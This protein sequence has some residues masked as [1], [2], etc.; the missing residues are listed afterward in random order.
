LV[1]PL[2]CALAGSAWAAGDGKACLEGVAKACIEIGTATA[3]DEPP[4]GD[5]DELTAEC[6]KTKDELTCAGL[7]REQIK[8]GCRHGKQ[9]ACKVLGESEA[10]EIAD[11]AA[12]TT[13]SLEASCKKKDQQAC[14]DLATKLMKEDPS[15]A[16]AKRALA[17]LDRSCKAEFADACARLGLIL[18]FDGKKSDAKRGEKLLKHAC[19][20]GSKA[21]CNFLPPQAKLLKPGDKSMGP[22]LFQT[23]DVGQVMKNLAKLSRLLEQNCKLGYADACAELEEPSDPDPS[24][25]KILTSAEVAEKIRKLERQAAAGPAPKK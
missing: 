3:N 19:D 20:L 8:E 10:R 23:D 2:V 11:Q 5:V 6:A 12:P 22:G 16:D 21:G 1:T 7:L 18:V 25:R 9:A 13:E 14:V 15:K 4:V 24:K 17:L